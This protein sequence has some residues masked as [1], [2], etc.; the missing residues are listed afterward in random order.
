VLRHLPQVTD[1]RVLA[2]SEGFEDAGVVRVTDDLALVQTVDFFTPVVD[3]PRDFGRIAAANAISDV[4]AMGGEPLSALAIAGYPSG[5]DADLIGEIFAG[6]A[7]TAAEA[8]IAIVGGH[9]VLAPEPFYGLV[10]TGTVHPER[11][12]RNSGARAGDVLVLTKPLGSGVVANALR[13]DAAPPDVLAAAVETMAALNRDAARRAR[14]AGGPHAATDVTGFGLLGHA[15]EM[16]EGAGLQLRLRLADLP[17]IAGAAELVS[18]GHVP[19][20][21]RNNRAAADAFATFAPGHDE[22]RAALACDAQTSGG[23]LLA[24]PASRAAGIG[25]VIGDVREGPA[26]TLLVS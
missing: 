9:T 13:H 20:G 19:G 12:W 16:A 1:P 26:G 24:L 7:A 6:G 22:V 2:G 23:L 15:R 4:Y 10:V 5:L 25:T 21:S 14:D 11:I 3:E 18:A 17:L 8:G